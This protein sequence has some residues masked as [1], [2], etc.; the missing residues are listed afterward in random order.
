MALGALLYFRE[1]GIRVPED[2]S[3]AGFDDNFFSKFLSPPLTS[4][5]L[6]MSEIGTIAME[7]LIRMIENSERP[8][9]KMLLPSRLV[10]R[11]STVSKI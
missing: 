8:N 11:E 10:K 6:P 3:L 2:I 5:K 4:V 1:N 7:S 9:I